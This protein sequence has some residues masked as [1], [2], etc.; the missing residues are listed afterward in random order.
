MAAADTITLAGGA[1]GNWS[2]TTNHSAAYNAT[3]ASI[4]IIVTVLY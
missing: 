3:N 4:K 1:T 2:I